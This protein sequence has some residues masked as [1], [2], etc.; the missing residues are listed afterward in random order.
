MRAVIFEERERWSGAVLLS[1]GLHGLLA[2]VI[3]LV[4]W[5]GGPRGE[6]WGE[7]STGDSVNA[8][9]V[10]SVPLPAPQQPTENILANESK[11]L[12]QTVPQIAVQP[13]DAIPIPDRQTRKKPDRTVRTTANVRPP[14][15]QP[16]ENVVPY[17]Q[18]GPISGPYGAFTASNAKGG[19]NFQ[20]GDFGSRFSWYVQQV[21]R[22]VS[23][24][25]Y[26]TEVDPNVTTAR[27]VYLT[28]DIMK[29]GT[30]VNVR[31]E[32][33]SGIPSL[34]QSA[35]RALQRIDTFG[36]LPPGYSGSKVSVEFWFDYQR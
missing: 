27:R 31:I 23:S 3:I 11:G 32:Q 17:G 21:N 1:T 9:L 30:P 10:S 14:V 25:W 33:S 29:D 8:T 7:T 36:P 4:A 34:D 12:T 6:T 15:T 16:V 24:H 20:S 26:R 18:G 13:P 28:F 5:F 2:I 22:T 19:F 35:M